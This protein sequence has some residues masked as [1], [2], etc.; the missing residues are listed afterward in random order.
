[1]EKKKILAGIVIAAIIIGLYLLFTSEDIP[2][3]DYPLAEYPPT[4]AIVNVETICTDEID[5]DGDRLTDNEDGDCWIRQGPVY[6][7]HPYY[8]PNHSFKEITGQIPSL[9]ELGIKTIYLMPIWMHEKIEPYHNGLYL[10]I[11]YYRIDP[12]YGTERDLRELINTAHEYDMKVLLDLVTA[13][14]PTRSILYNWTLKIP[15]TTLQETGLKLKTQHI[16]SD[17]EH[18]YEGDFIYSSDCFK[19]KNMMCKV[20]GKIDGETVIL[21]TYPKPKFGPALD[22]T[23]PEVV[24]YFTNVAGYYIREYDIDGW[25]LDSTYNTWNP[26]LFLGDHSIIKLT[27]NMK[28]IDNKGRSGTILLAEHPSIEL[29]ETNEISYI[30]YDLL[31]KQIGNGIVVEH[32]GSHKL[33]DLL[34]NDTIGHNR[35]RLYFGE[36]HDSPRGNALLPQINKPWIVFISTIPGVPMIQAGQEIGANNAWFYDGKTSRPQVDWKNGDYQLREFYK[37]VFNIRNSNNALKYG[38]I[39]NI[40]KSGDNTYA[41]SRTY[42]DERVVIV[43]NFNGKEVTSVL[44]VPYKRGDRLKD[45]LS[46]EIFTV[47]DPTNFR[48]SVPAYGSRILMLKE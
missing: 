41:Y 2:L 45:K 7:T 8:Y 18:T 17:P 48:V 5:N 28:K 27:R 39:Q 33:V 1:M 47:V 36:T 10:I 19:N 43:I 26:E 3:E 14:A 11:D 29:D 30:L 20:F 38:D 42:D 40:W 31:F 24:D 44:D 37:R 4:A 35:T 46:D 16:D 25:R 22:R 21:Y 6:E 15:L 32:I 23:N 34:K 13:V 12:V 9:S